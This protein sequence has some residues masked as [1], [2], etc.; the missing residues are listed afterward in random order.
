MKKILGGVILILLIAGYAWA[1][2]IQI[3]CSRGDYANWDVWYEGSGG[4]NSSGPAKFHFENKSEASAW[5]VLFIVNY[6]DYFGNYLG[7]DEK[8]YRGPLHKNQFKEFD[9]EIPPK[10]DKLDCELYWTKEYRGV[11][12]E[13]E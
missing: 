9:G 10:T 5:H 1:E 13:E 2:K 4:F 12:T 3:K 6:Y 8:K 11:D 7:R